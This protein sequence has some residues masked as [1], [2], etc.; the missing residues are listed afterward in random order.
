M[1]ALFYD[2]P[3]TTAY[4]DVLGSPVQGDT[5]AIET[6]VVPVPSGSLPS[7]GPSPSH[8]PTLWR[9]TSLMHAGRRASASG[10]T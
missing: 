3:G 8:R 6:L 10:L 7:S 5:D 2:G 4:K 9:Q 1:T